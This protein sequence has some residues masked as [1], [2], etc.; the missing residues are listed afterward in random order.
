MPFILSSHK[1]NDWCHMD[2]WNRSL[3]CGPTEVTGASHTLTFASYRPCASYCPASRN[4]KPMNY[5][6]YWNYRKISR[7]CPTSWRQS[8]YLD[9]HSRILG[10]TVVHIGI[11]SN[12]TSKTQS[13]KWTTIETT[14]ILQDVQ[15]E[16]NFQ[17]ITTVKPSRST[18]CITAS[19]F[20]VTTTQM[21][22]IKTN[23][24]YKW[25]KN[26]RKKVWK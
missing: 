12:I 24:S 18:V 21:K 9:V 2:T 5:P 4:R 19:L 23:K 22:L 17:C 3:R 20:I 26:G 8:C 25:D 16:L 6:Y 13:G 1:Q 7:T 10:K 14:P 11:I 15:N